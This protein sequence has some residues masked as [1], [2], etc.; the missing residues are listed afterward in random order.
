MLKRRPR[1]K[2]KPVFPLGHPGW[3]C[4]HCGMGPDSGKRIAGRSGNETRKLSLRRWSDEG[5]LS[6]VR[7]WVLKLRATGLN[8]LG[9]PPWFH[10]EK[11]SFELRAA[12]HRVEHALHKLNLE[13]LVS[14]P[15]HHGPHDSGRGGPM[16]WACDSSWQGDLYTVLLPDREESST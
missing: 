14:R 6:A 5:L 12:P 9:Q 8:H 10:R 2:G 3:N 15:V 11:I 13:G 16:D 1:T 7:E 4:R